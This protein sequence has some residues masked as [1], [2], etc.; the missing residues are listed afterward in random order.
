MTTNEIRDQI[1]RGKVKEAIA[2]LSVLATTEGRS[3][4]SSEV[5]LHSSKFKK[6]ERDNR[7]GII[8]SDDYLKTRNKI[9]VDILDLLGQMDEPPVETPITTKP[10][11]VKEPGLENKPP[12]QANSQTSILFLAANPSGTSKLQ[13]E[14]EHSRVSREIQLSP[15]PGKFRI[16]PSKQ[17]TTFRDLQSYLVD[18]EPDII[19]FSGHGKGQGDASNDPA[20]ENLRDLVTDDQGELRDDTGIVLASDDQRSYEI[21]GT[22]VIKETFSLLADLKQPQAIQLV[23]FN[24]CYS[25]A[26][27]EAIAG[28][29]EFVIGTSSAVQ[30]EAAIAFATSFYLGLAKGKD[31]RIAYKLGRAAAMQKKEKRDKFILYHKGQRVTDV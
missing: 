23:L 24:S 26:Q 1:S 22:E 21:V 20:F 31:L 29:A 14:K 13:L 11:P 17:A 5:L 2:A 15:N 9:T 28:M 18:E 12:Q 10:L 6:N 4:I 8:S 25:N 7:M 19:H 30:D 27:A 3:E 16:I